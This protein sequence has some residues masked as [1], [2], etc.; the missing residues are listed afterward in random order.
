[1]K[2][3]NS[4]HDAE[5]AELLRRV[6]LRLT[7][8]RRYVLEAL[9]QSGHPLSHQE[10]LGRRDSLRFDR[11]TIYRALLALKRKGL[12]HDVKGTDGIRRFGAHPTD[13]P[14]CPGNHAHFLCRRC[15]R[16]FCLTESPLPWVEVPAGT[17]VEGKQMVVYGLCPQC[18][19]RED[20]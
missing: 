19:R 17:T 13:L 5:T 6:G 3:G 11:V 15:G 8:S 2:R 9:L 14:H 20:D 16:M 12:V 4:S 18:A 10:L 1:M 7:G